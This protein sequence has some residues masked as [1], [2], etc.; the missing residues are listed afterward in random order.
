MTPQGAPQTQLPLSE[1]ASTNQQR[2]VEKTCR[3]LPLFCSI[4]IIPLQAIAC[5]QN[6]PASLALLSTSYIFPPFS[7]MPASS[8]FSEK[9][10]LLLP[11][12]LALAWPLLAQRYTT[13]EST[14]PKA[15]AAYLEGRR[16]LREGN[17]FRGLRF[18][19]DA[20]REDSTLIDAHML[21]AE[22][23]FDQEQWEA[24]ARGYERVLR[25]NPTYHPSASFNMALCKWNLD[26]FEEASAYIEMFLQSGVKDARLLYRARRLAENS[27]FAAEAV[28]NSV[29]FAPR[30]VG[31]TINT[32]S[33][34]YLPSL[35]ADGNTMI[36]TRRD[37]Y[38]E[39]FYKSERQPDGSW[40][41]AENL[42]GVN[43]LQNEGAQAINADGR[44][45]VFTACNRRN[46]GSQG[47]CDLYW[48]Q[49]KDG[50]WT[51][52]VPFSAAVNSAY[53][54]A[55]PTISPDNKTIFFSSDRPGGQGGKDLWF[56]TRLPNGRFTEPQNLGAPINT[57]GDEQAPFL[58]PDGQTL[59]F[60]SD[61]LPGMGNNDL[62]FSRRN[63]AGSWSTPQN[64]GYPINTKGHEGTLVVSL[65]GSTAYYAAVLPGGAG[66]LDIYSFDMPAHAR[67]RP[68]TYV[69]A[70]VTDAV[71][72]RP[73]VARAVCT[74]L[75]TGQEYIAAYTQADGSFLICLQA[76]KDFALN[77]SKENYLFHSEHFNLA[78]TA[79]FDQPF[80]LRIALQPLTPADEAAPTPPPARP[81]V[82]RNVFFETGSAALKP[83]STVELDQL[84]ALLDENPRLRIQ[85]NG[86]TDDVGDDA[87]NQ[88]LS[89]RRA[90]A[91]YDY[92]VSKGIAPER[93][94]YR[95]FGE[96]KPIQPND[97]PE[98]RAQNRRTEFEV[99]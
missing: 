75:T 5:W 11:L 33:D 49:L 74:D 67:P 18:L 4:G 39:D 36:F 6:T 20:I 84:V 81:V 99:W 79:S 90:K 8:F 54:D 68:V 42:R 76:G 21:W 24:A 12:F 46:D 31:P 27:R 22:V 1:D 23:H 41:R 19:E 29:P 59:Y 73:L 53:W 37:L 77:V 78:Q 87:S 71:T 55:Q 7:T 82:L 91:V 89:E 52:P 92:L 63:P 10:C 64:L 26:R 93:L 13:A 88:A 95:G 97:T 72:G 38:N 43:T 61:G 14:S 40:G 44:W 51:K 25:L 16:Y 48:S 86:H 57:P 17:A 35:T 80:L 60:T 98:G 30:S 3:I 96:S 32:P 50:A 66:G 70:I 65:D 47:S 85:I 2:D 28:K 94:R 15:R 56:T 83:A 45:L 34:E 58:H 69:K 62:Y 9:H